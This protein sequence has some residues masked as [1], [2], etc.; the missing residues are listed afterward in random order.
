M[1]TYLAVLI[2]ILAFGIEAKCQINLDSA[3]IELTKQY[4]LLLTENDNLRTTVNDLTTNQKL[5]DANRWTKIKSN[6]QSSTEAYKLLGDKT[7]TLKTIFINT[8]FQKFVNSLSSIDKNPLGFSF[9]DVI[10]KAATSQTM[11]SKKTTGE[12]FINTVEAITKSPLINLIPYA[13]EAVKIS[14]SIINVAYSAGIHKSKVDLSKIQKFEED[15]NKYI[16]YYVKLDSANAIN[17]VT[18]V[19]VITLIEGIQSDLIKKIQQD[20]EN[21]NITLRALKSGESL[22]LYLR[23]CLNRYSKERIDSIISV[24]EQGKTPEQILRRETSLILVNNTLDDFIEI[25]KKFRIVFDSYFE[26][27]SKYYKLIGNSL[28]TAKKNGIIEKTDKKTP[29]E[30]YTDLITL[31]KEKARLKD[32]SIRTAI[33]LEELTAKMKKIYLF[34][35]I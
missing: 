27:E 18:V 23:E 31:F 15:L 25:E 22:D 16:S 19:Q 4:R 10:K 35:V 11:F 17:S 28:L 2:L 30:I 34:K 14:N 6:L 12:K 5:T 21:L 1:K 3:V 7:I 26:L 29:D 13:S 32:S 33:N 20:S 24:K 8:D 9:V